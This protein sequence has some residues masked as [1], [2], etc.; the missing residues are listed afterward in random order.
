MSLSHRNQSMNCS[1]N[2]LTGFYVRR[3]LTIKGLMKLCELCKRSDD[4]HEEYK[5]LP[6][7]NK[8]CY[9]TVRKK[10]EQLVCIFQLTLFSFENF[11]FLSYLINLKLCVFMITMYCV[12]CI[13]SVT[14]LKKNFISKISFI[15]PQQINCICKYIL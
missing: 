1:A 9:F 7:R 8:K 11:M 15:T 4:Y 10:A 2:Q 6:N 13:S 12:S 5:A 14:C 3:T